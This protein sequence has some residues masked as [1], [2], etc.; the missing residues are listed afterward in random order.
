[1]A[2]STN[3]PK[4]IYLDI[5]GTTWF[6]DEHIVMPSTLEALKIL[7]NK[8]V[9]LFICTSRAYQ[10]TITLPTEYTN[11]LTGY[12]VG[13]GSM[14][15]IDNKCV[16][17]DLMQ[18]EDTKKIID[19]LDKKNLVYRWLSA[20]DECYL[21]KIDMDKMSLFYRL[22][23]Y[24]PAVR[25]YQNQEL[26]HLLF[27]INEDEDMDEINPYLTHMNIIDLGKTKEMVAKGITKAHG[28]KAVAK[29]YGTTLKETAAFGDGYN[30]IEMLQVAGISI[31]MGNAYDE[32]KEEADYV[33]AR[34]EDDGLY[35][36]CKH[37]DWL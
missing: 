25:A 24:V 31:A 9:K 13:A 4:I 33:T 5:D 8:G 16:Y 3:L 2:S 1:M 29:H 21:N 28:M 18:L 23:A 26:C 7:K 17:H 15:Y 20:N 37:F 35:L 32:V 12:I 27:Y 14:V 19:I 36:A 6:N 10:E 30:D 11:L 22:Y 34:I